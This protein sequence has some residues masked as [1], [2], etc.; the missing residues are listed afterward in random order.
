MAECRYCMRGE[1]DLV[2]EPRV[3][4]ELDHVIDRLD[5]DL[6]VDCAQM[7]FI[8]STGIRLLVETQERLAAKGRELLI[9]N[10]R[11][12]PRRVFEVLGL[13]DML[14]YDRQAS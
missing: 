1:I 10:V 12:G 14:R 6:L 9:V 7:T 4:V 5:A 11:S 2:V 3:R 13:T 8:D